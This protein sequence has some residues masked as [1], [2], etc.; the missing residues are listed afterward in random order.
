M[1]TVGAGNPTLADLAKRM[2]GNKIADV[3]ELL[4]ETNEILDSMTWIEGNLSTGHRTTVRSGLPS[5]TWRQLNY[6]VQPSKSRTVQVTDACGMLESYAEVDKALA[7]LNGNEKA[8][9][10]SEDR[11]FLESMNQEFA[12]T[13]FYGNTDTDP[14]EF[15]GLAHRYSSLSAENAENILVGGS[16]TDS[17]NTSIWLVVWGPNTIHGIY[18]KGSMAGL[19]MRDLGEET[20]SDANGGL[21]QGYRTHYKWDCGLTLRD[22]RYV[23]RIPN[24][25]VASLTKDKSAGADINDLMVQAIE[26]IRNMGMGRAVFYCN[27]TIRSMLRRQILNTTNVNLTLDT[28]AGR[29]IVHFDGIPVQRCDAILNTESLVA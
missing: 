8:F 29:K 10:M 12:E 9:R 7:D 19:N 23:V 21:Y 16:T 25:N 1:A 20:L 11:A 14:E 22:W 13:M 24:I 26:L 4:N 17:V 18:P 5:V 3:I 27:Q 15:M 6:G 2:E 28:H